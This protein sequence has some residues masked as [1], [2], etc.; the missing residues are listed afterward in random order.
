MT[1]HTQQQRVLNALDAYQ[2]ALAI[3]G[4]KRAFELLYRRWHP[5]LLRFALRRTGHV[6]VAKDVMQEAALAMAKNISR[7]ED[8]ERFAAWAYTIVRRRAAD[9][10][11]GMVKDRE[12]RASLAAQPSLQAE[13]PCEEALSIKQAL[14]QLPPCD[15]LMLT[16]F[17][18]DGLK[19]PE[20]AA[21]MGIPLGT[22]K[23]R[24]F[25]ARGKLKSIYENT[26][27]GDEND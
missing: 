3:D 4:D 8:P 9:Q 21:A 13:Q 18:V 16:L 23:S 2:A 14:R 26:S 1:P 15:R 27:K 11:S 24:L 7:L 22:L 17:Y 20:M 5:L 12:G 6:E 10:I 19:G 25:T